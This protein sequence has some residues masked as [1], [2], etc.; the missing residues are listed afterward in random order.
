MHEV[1]HE[2]A[3][4][5]LSA[6]VLGGIQVE[7]RWTTTPTRSAQVDRSVRRANLEAALWLIGTALAVWAIVAFAVAVSMFLNCLVVPLCFIG[8][9]FILRG[10]DDALRDKRRIRSEEY[11]KGGPVD[12]LRDWSVSFDIVQEGV[13][14]GRDSGKL[15]FQDR[16]AHFVGKA[17]SF[18]LTNRQL[19]ERGSI[20]RRFKPLAPIERGIE[21]RLADPRGEGAW[22]VQ[23][24]AGD[25]A[26]VNAL[27]GQLSAVFVNEAPPGIGQFPPRGLGP[28]YLARRTVWF[29]AGPFAILVVM[30]AWVGLWLVALGL[31]TTLP[32]TEFF[33]PFLRSAPFFPAIVISLFTMGRFA[34]SWRRIWRYLGNYDSVIRRARNHA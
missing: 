20:E 34:S 31:R 11:W 9:V 25:P 30:G 27:Y 4:S 29:V 5:P 17:T 23:L 19:A 6:P 16:G 26:V 12:D 2:S 14:T 22:S 21:I 15:W 18:V 13:V 3:T 10:V 1:D 24:D 33:E 28:G 32:R 7:S 8:G